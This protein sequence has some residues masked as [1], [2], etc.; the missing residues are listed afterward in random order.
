MWNVEILLPGTLAKPSSR[1]IPVT[2]TLVHPGPDSFD[3]SP[4]LA[5][6]NPPPGP[7]IL[8][9]TP[10]TRSSSSPPPCPS[11]PHLDVATDAEPTFDRGVGLLG[12][13]WVA[14]A[15]LC[16]CPWRCT[17]RRTT[18]CRSPRG[19]YT[20]WPRRT[21]GRSPARAVRNQ[22]PPLPPQFQA[23]REGLARVLPRRK[24]RLVPIPPPSGPG[25]GWCE[26]CGGVAEVYLPLEVRVEATVI[27]TDPLSTWCRLLAGSMHWRFAQVLLHVQGLS[28]TQTC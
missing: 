15:P 4:R 14:P 5:K 9:N 6:C 13:D 27:A 23:P 22:S 12:R 2:G 11:P 16:C 19:W 28:S 17:P 26:S 21:P 24:T 1:S 18:P 10:T 25:A 8:P 7:V 20:C 3:A